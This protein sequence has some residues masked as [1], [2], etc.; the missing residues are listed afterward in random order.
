MPESHS[1]FLRFD[2][3]LQLMLRRFCI[4]LLAGNVNESM[5]LRGFD[6]AANFHLIDY[7]TK[8]KRLFELN[9]FA[10]HASVKSAIIFSIVLTPST[11]PIDTASFPIHVLAPLT[12]SMLIPSRPRETISLNW[13]K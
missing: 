7:R 8:V 12:F 13:L 1:V 6:E 2:F 10:G 3:I 9:H 4:L 11:N 5:P